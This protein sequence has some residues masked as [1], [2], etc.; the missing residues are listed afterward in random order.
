MAAASPIL[1]R[2]AFFES[3]EPSV[4]TRMRWYIRDLLLPAELRRPSGAPR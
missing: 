2:T 4:A 3:V 1:L